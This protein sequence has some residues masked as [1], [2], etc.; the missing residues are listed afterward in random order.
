M[1][2]LERQASRNVGRRRHPLWLWLAFAGSALLYGVPAIWQLLEYLQ[3]PFDLAIYDQ[4]L[5]LL[6]NGESFITVAGKHVNTAHFSPILYLISPIAFIPGG[7]IPELV[8]QSLLVATG[9][10]PAW[11]LGKTLNQD[12]RWFA[13][14]YAIHPAII[15]G[16]WFGF[17]P[18]NLAAPLFMWAT[19]WIVDKPSTFRIITSGLALLVF[20]E[21]LAVWVGLLVL[22]LLLAKRVELK[23]LLQSGAVLGAATALILFVILPARSFVDEYY[24]TSPAQVGIDTAGI[25]ALISSVLIR[26]LFLLLPLAIM[27][28]KINWL[29]MA[30]LSIPIAGLL[31]RGGNSLTTFY[32]YDMMFVAILL[33]IAGLS[34]TVAY[35]PGLLATM[36][37]TVL[38]LFGALRPFEPRGGGNPLR[39]DA[40]ISQDL[41]AIKSEIAS[42]PQGEA[43]SMSVPPR[44]VAHYS[45]RS[46]IFIHPFP[47]DVWDDSRDEQPPFGIRFNC[48]DP[49][50]VVTHP[51]TLET[52]WEAVLSSDYRNH[53]LPDNAFEIWVRNEPLPDRPCAAVRTSE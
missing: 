31:I 6:A 43:A 15:G 45:E 46:N 13:L 39:Y 19:W 23:T 12:P 32:H 16:S 42:F 52:E 27:P 7:A 17:R 3:T 14:V 53:A 26:S 29:L 28:R 22:V 9:V 1:D 33:V 21:D 2:T 38:V 41:D 20:R 51:P 47:L 5:W 25:P 30:P 48:P 10:F 24:F 40:A 35:R 8:F 18:W 50:I 4:A 49:T 37:L 36:S 34:T 11:R 44:L